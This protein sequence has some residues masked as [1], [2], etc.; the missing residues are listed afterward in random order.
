[1]I[2]EEIEK[3]CL[4]HTTQESRLLSE[5]SRKTHLRTLMPRMLS[6]NIQGKF[7]GLLASINNAQNILEIGT[8]TGYS[9]ISMAEITSTET[10]I[11]TIDK[12]VELEDFVREEF[13]K[14][15]YAKK[16][17]FIVGDALE[18]IPRITEKFDMIF[19]DADKHNYL[20]YYKLSIPLLT[21][22][23]FIVF[24]NVLWSGKV[25]GEV[26]PSDRDTKGL[27]EFNEY[28]KNDESVIKVMLPL[29][30]GLMMVKKVD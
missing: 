10:R 29:R 11:T 16:I 13:E 20:N 23:G 19:V 18:V 26:K 9:A 8:F 17:N 12:N 14:S 25:L 28:L 24:D 22:K 1:M 3:Y 30:D 4:L 15:G 21:K 2:N 6:G 27:V 7:L 5:L